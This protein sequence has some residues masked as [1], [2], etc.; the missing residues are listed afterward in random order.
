MAVFSGNLE[1]L[2]IFLRKFLLQPAHCLISMSFVYNI[3]TAFHILFNLILFNDTCLF[4][5]DNQISF[6]FYKQV[7]LEIFITHIGSTNDVKLKKMFLLSD[8]I[9]LYVIFDNHLQPPFN[10]NLEYTYVIIQQ[11]YIPFIHSLFTSVALRCSGSY[12]LV[13]LPQYIKLQE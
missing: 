13:I 6:Q 12:P 11:P 10:F 9:I 1:N 4:E 8:D 5:S 2:R 3:N 7:Y